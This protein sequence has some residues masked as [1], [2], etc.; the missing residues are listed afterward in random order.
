M[1]FKKYDEWM[2]N[3]IGTFRI[4]KEFLWFTR[5]FDI[6]KETRWLEFAEIVEVVT[7]GSSYAGQYPF[8]WKKIGFLDEILERYD[9]VESYLRFLKITENTRPSGKPPKPPKA[10]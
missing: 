7:K 8:Y 6:S 5:S 4:V 1:R 3:N 10:E 2:K 9:T